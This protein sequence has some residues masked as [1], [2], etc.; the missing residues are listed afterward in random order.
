MIQLKEARTLLIQA[1][2]LL[3]DLDGLE[4]EDYDSVNNHTHSDLSVAERKSLRLELAQA[5]KDLLM[6]VDLCTAAGQLVK[7]RYWD[8]KGELD[9]LE[10]LGIEKEETPAPA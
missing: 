1:Q 8:Y 4:L 2:E 10:A 7:L 5:S 6:L 9:T 3:E